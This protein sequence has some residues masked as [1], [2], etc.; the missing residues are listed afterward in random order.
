MDRPLIFDVNSNIHY[1]AE[2]GIKAL[3]PA[4]AIEVTENLSVGFTL[5]FWLDAFGGRKWM[6]GR[7]PSILRNYH[8]REIQIELI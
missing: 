1:K 7:I 8:S 4:Y 2:G 5:N 3:S 6:E